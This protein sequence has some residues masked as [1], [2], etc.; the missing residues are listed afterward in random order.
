M[1][2]I[3][4]AALSMK[5]LLTR[6]SVARVVGDLLEGS[7]TPAEAQRWA[8]FMRWGF[9]G[10]WVPEQPSAMRIKLV[11]IDYELTS[12]DDIVDALSQL[13]QIGDLI[14]GDPSQDE[15]QET[16]SRLR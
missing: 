9:P 2:S 11:D 15:L 8:L 10:N 1:R 4:D 5:L 14:D 13:D 12:E 7:I 3:V 6:E 16:L